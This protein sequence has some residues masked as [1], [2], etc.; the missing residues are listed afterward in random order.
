VIP[1]IL[2]LL[3]LAAIFGV[4]AAVLKITLVI[5][6]STLLTI[7]VLVAFGYY[8]IRY[9]VHRLRRDVERTYGDG[10]RRDL[11]PGA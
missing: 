1:L 3:L 5:V 9:R 10:H 2:I 11:P 4:L 6:L 7:A 8:W